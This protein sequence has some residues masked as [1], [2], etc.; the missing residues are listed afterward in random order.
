MPPRADRIKALWVLG[1]FV[2]LLI[3]ALYPPL[4]QPWWQVE[5]RV[6]SV[7]ARISQARA[8]QASR[9][10]IEAS[11]AALRAQALAA[12]RYLPEPNAAL[13]SAALTQRI[14]QAVEAGATHDS[15]CV[16]GNRLALTQDKLASCDAVGI[17]V[18]MQ[19]GISAL[20]NV[21]QALEQEAPRLTIDAMQV[22]VAPNP[23]GFDKPSSADQPLDV[24]FEVS[25]CLLPA[26]LSSGDTG[27]GS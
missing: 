27:V 26:V 4:L 25:G 17:R 9:P 22:G 10:G 24:T 16:L 5:F 23:L 20:H 2:A 13:A 8:L 12:G 7:Q 1:G 18:T 11:I 14:Q 6:R 19:C 15:V 3:A 21:L